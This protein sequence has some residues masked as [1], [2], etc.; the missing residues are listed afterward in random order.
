[1]PGRTGAGRVVL[2]D[3]VELL[4]WLEH[5]PGHLRL[6]GVVAEAAGD[7]GDRSGLGGSR[8]GSAASVEPGVAGAGETVGKG[9][10]R[11][12]AA[13]LLRQDTITR[14]ESGFQALLDPRRLGLRA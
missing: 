9:R 12:G 6:S 3:A 14:P 8:D 11:H 10:K 4:G 7:V 13:S 5:D 1:M 2:E